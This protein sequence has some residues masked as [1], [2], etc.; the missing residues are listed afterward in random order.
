MNNKT[1]NPVAPNING[2]WASSAKCRWKDYLTLC[3]ECKEKSTNPH[4]LLPT[5]CMIP[6]RM[7]LSFQR[8]SVG[9]HKCLDITFLWVGG[10]CPMLGRRKTQRTGASRTSL[11]VNGDRWTMWP[12][13]GELSLDT[14]GKD[15]IYQG[16][17]NSLA[18]VDYILNKERRSF[19][20]GRRK[21]GGVVAY[22]LQKMP[23][24]ECWLVYISNLK[25]FIRLVKT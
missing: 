5:S 16:Y 23:R 19:F 24:H 20:Q 15:Q 11:S 7:L 14:E 18:S 9:W 2:K 25:L 6:G 8:W 17:E 21:Y 4:P 12:L 10:V 1:H 13:Q 3:Q 22:H